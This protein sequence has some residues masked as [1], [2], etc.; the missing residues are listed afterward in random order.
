MET[1]KEKFDRL[2][3]ELKS[4]EI[5]LS[6]I[7]EERA[8]LIKDNYKYYLTFST[9]G[10]SGDELKEK[11]N[12]EHFK[13][14][15]AKLK[16]SSKFGEQYCEIDGYDYIKDFRVTDID[17]TKFENCK[18]RFL[19]ENSDFHVFVLS[20]GD[21]QISNGQNRYCNLT[22]DEYQRLISHNRRDE[23]FQ[24][25]I[26]GDSELALILLNNE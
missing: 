19:N 17:F 23:L 1:L 25:I 11:Y 8:K 21:V 3:N 22:N 15:K 12:C 20:G 18:F 2:S 7:K 13:N 10:L 24:L 4:A 14:L 26:N 9:Y 5:T 16:S 6:N